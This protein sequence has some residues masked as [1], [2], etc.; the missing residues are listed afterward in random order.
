MRTC[1][2]SCR[3]NFRRCRSRICAYWPRAGTIVAREA[4]FAE[5]GPITE[6]WA[7]RARASA[8]LYSVTLAFYARQRSESDLEREAIAGIMRAIGS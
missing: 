2:G 5:Y 8:L 7:T 6:E 4:L 1:D 3:R